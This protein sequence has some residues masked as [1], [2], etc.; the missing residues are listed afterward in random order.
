MGTLSQM[1]KRRRMLLGR[2]TFDDELNEEMRFHIDMITEDNVVAGMLATTPCA[3][4]GIGRLWKNDHAKCGLI[5]CWQTCCR[6][7][8][9][10]CE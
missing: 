9:V 6:I 10:G 8:A 7:F 5:E 2:R 4:S 3:V 1:L